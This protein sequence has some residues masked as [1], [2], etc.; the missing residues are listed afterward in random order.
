[1]FNEAHHTIAHLKHD[2]M[3]WFDR[4]PQV[5]EFVIFPDLQENQVAPFQVDQVQHFPQEAGRPPSATDVPTSLILLR[6][7]LAKE[8]Q[9]S[10]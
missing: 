5:G 3:M 10:S 1:M 2:Q 7:I 8:Q 4:V 6:P 9:P